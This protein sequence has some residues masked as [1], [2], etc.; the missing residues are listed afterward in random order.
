MK[1]TGWKRICD[2][3]DSNIF[4]KTWHELSDKEKK[5][6]IKEYGSNAESAWEEWGHKPCKL[7]FGFVNTEGEF[8]KKITDIPQ[9]HDFMQVYKVS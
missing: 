6:W 8:F 2:V 5:P 9:L 1:L 7:P 3:E 4:Y